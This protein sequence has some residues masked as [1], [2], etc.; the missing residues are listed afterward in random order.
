MKAMG[1][2]WPRSSAA[3]PELKFLKP[4]QGKGL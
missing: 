2:C 3:R 4:V 1:P